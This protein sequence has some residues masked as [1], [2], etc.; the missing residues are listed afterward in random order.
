LVTV[1]RG[2]S[3]LRNETR[4]GNWQDYNKSSILS[5]TDLKLSQ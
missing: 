4:R 5:L 1:N 2:I 3:Y